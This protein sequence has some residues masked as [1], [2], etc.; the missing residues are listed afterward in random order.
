MA[1]KMSYPM[2]SNA[3]DHQK[4]RNLFERCVELEGIVQKH[5]ATIRRLVDDVRICKAALADKA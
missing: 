4:M 1:M 2:W 3:S 5:E